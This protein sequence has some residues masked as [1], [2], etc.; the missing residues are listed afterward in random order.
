M[1]LGK[2]QN[3]TTSIDTAVQVSGNPVCSV[4]CH[5]YTDKLESSN[6]Q[7]W[8]QSRG[9]PDNKVAV[10]EFRLLLSDKIVPQEVYIFFFFFALSNDHYEIACSSF[11][12]NSVPFAILSGMLWDTRTGM[13]F[14]TGMF[15]VRGAEEM[16][17]N[18]ILNSVEH[19][20][21]LK[22]LRCFYLL[23]AH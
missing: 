21:V 11:L 9:I 18:D 15:R 19:F 4:K 16:R 7:F 8:V 10:A 5:T 20:E 2:L 14:L 1:L 6:S 23:T 22:L 3:F 13:L 12:K 17:Q